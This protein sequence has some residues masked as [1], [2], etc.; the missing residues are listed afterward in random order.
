MNCEIRA[1]CSMLVLPIT[2]ATRSKA[3]PATIY[4]YLSPKIP[5]NVGIASTAARYIWPIRRLMPVFLVF[6][7]T[8]FGSSC[9]NRAIYENIQQNQLR[10]CEELPIPQQAQCKAQYGTTYEQYRRERDRIGQN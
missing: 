8:V 3:L 7:L 2:A 9:S 1:T 6:S 5:K 4:P 10:A